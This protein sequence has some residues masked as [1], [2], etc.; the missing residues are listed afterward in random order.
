M[1]NIKSWADHCSSDEESDDDRIA[2]PPS[3]LPGSTSFNQLGNMAE[4]S[5]SEE[6]YDEPPPKEY[7]IPN[8]PPFTAFLGSLHFDLQTSNDLGHELERMLEGRQC[9]VRIRDCRLMTD[10]ETGK[11]RGYG[12]LEVGSPEEVRVILLFLLSVSFIFCGMII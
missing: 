12:Y 7:N 6:E 4:D 2:P 5:E 9:R 8:A 10:R 3:G 11:S 1:A